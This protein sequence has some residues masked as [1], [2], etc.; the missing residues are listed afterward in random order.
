MSILSIL[1]SPGPGYHNNYPEFPEYGDTFMGEA[2]GE[3]KGEAHC[4]IPRF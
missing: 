3:A 4:N 1:S 2:E